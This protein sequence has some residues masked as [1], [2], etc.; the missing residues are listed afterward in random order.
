MAAAKT[1]KLNTD[2]L[3]LGVTLALTCIG[4]L[5][6]YDTSYAYALQRHINP[7]KYVRQQALFAALGIPAMLFFM[8]FHYRRW[9]NA[10]L[11][12]VGASIILL[13][14]VFVP[15]IGGHEVNG[16]RRWIGMG[17]FTLQPSE[18]AK[19]AIVV[20]I[21]RL[22]AGRPKLMAR[23]TGGPLI[24]L[25]MMGLLALL[26]DR[27]PDLGTTL[28]LLGAGMGALFFAGMRMRHFAAVLGVLIVV[29]GG[30]LF[31]KSHG[32]EGSDQAVASAATSGGS[33]GY[34]A[35]RIQVWLHPELNH[36][37]EGYQVYHGMIALGSGGLL[38]EGVGNGREKIYLP[39]SYTDFIFA[40]VGEEG[41]LLA[42]LFVL[43][44]YAVLIGRG[45]QIASTTKDPFGAILAGGITAS[46]ATQTLLNIGVVTASIPATGVPLPFLS[47][48]GSS[49]F[50]SLVCVG[51]LLSVHRYSDTDETGRKERESTMPERDFERRWSKPA[52]TTSVTIPTHNGGTNKPLV[53]R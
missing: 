10:G 27:E 22:C 28:V 15:H 41:G 30:M 44:L 32:H 51:V 24:P 40:T 23:F 53:R 52:A 12:L 49:L 8:K 35:S 9:W 25:C 48:G 4:I 16:A 42:T 13:I 2:F 29:I 20:Y 33:N 21:A 11:M 18:L 43:A 50:M 7:L 34:R 5:L 38:G 3:L 31:L 26:I 47:Y 45:M 19:L 36:T 39:E 14:A 17:A 6:I 46:L 1:Q 37:G